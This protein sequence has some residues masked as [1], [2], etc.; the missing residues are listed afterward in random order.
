[1]I[2]RMHNLGIKGKRLKQ[3]GIAY[4]I[5][6]NEQSKSHVEINNLIEKETIEKQL[7]FIEKGINQYL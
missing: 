7:T 2:Q 1:M 5:F 6:H 4:H 3:V